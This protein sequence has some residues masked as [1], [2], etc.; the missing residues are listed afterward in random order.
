MFAFDYITKIRGVILAEMDVSNRGNWSSKF[1]FVLAAAGSA[2][3]LGNIWKF[4][5]VVADNGGAAFIFIYV[6]CILVVGFPVMV[7]ELTIGRRTSKNPVGAFKALSRNKFF[8]LIGAW[9]I[10]CG[11]MILAFYNVVAGWTLSFILEEIA[12]FVG[13]PHLSAF[14]ADLSHGPQNALFSLIF[15]TATVS[16]IMGGVSNGIEKA[17][18][19]MMPVLLGILVMLIFYVLTQNGSLAGVKQYLIP[20]FTKI[21]TELIFSAMGQAFFS[22]SLGMGA[23]ITYG[24]YLNKKQN[25]PEAAA[26]VVLADFLVAFLAGLLIIPALFVAQ[27]HGIGIY[28]KGSL[29]SSV[30]LVFQ[31]LPNLF[32]SM[33]PWIGFVFGVMFF[34]LLSLAA[35]TSTI[36]LLEVPVAY[37]ID[38]HGIPRKKAAIMIGGFIVLISIVISFDINWINILS[39]VFNN[40][41]LP[42]GG[43]MICVFLAYFWKTGNALVE[44]K[45]GYSNVEHSLFGHFWP[46]FVKYISP[47]LIGIV[48]Y[49][50]IR[51][52]L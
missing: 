18:K 21:N 38:E 40:I 9:G 41:G 4:P 13:M 27:A 30:G 46:Y 3:G 20:D 26:Y 25:I 29:I 2:V 22:L 39:V 37:A 42:F 24:S 15:M 49:N 28:S 50:A 17:T 8:P 19:A 34:L 45:E 36:S 6:I 10:I 35:L 11:I 32:H 48:F 47:L 23:M 51:T 33:N 43:L 44:I 1:G 14:F 52:F 12:Y 16:I 7:A 5:N 31:I